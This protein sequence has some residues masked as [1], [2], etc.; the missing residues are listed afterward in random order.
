MELL[1]SNQLISLATV[2]KV[3]PGKIREKEMRYLGCTVDAHHS[4]SHSHTASTA[5]ASLNF[6][7][8]FTSRLML[9]LAQCDKTD[10]RLLGFEHGECEYDP[11]LPNSHY[12]TSIK[13]ELSASRV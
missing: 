3:Q 6:A 10:Y 8:L 12:L 13:F 1:S 4:Y 7:P 11:P 9:V 2:Q 5:N